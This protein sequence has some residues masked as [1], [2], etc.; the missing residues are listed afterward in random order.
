[1]TPTDTEDLGPPS[2]MELGASRERDVLMHRVAVRPQWWQKALGEVGLAH[3]APD[4]AVLSWADLFTLADA[5]T[6]SAEAA[7]RLLWACLSWG[8]RSTTPTQPSAHRL[9]YSGSAQRG[10]SAAADRADSAPR[11]AGRLQ[12][13]PARQIS[14]PYLGP[15]FFTK[16]LY[17]AGGGRP[18]HPCLILDARAAALQNHCGWSSLRGRSWWPPDTYGRYCALLHRWSRELS[19]P[20][21]P[22]AADQVEKALFDRGSADPAL[23][24]E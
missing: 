14:D 18:D 20:Q 4:K 13:P 12:A 10:C 17:A 16:F 2:W 15:P 7:R 23:E 11:R 6:E 24:D 9:H 3:E 8:Y 5:A 21:R 1:M 22:V 19:T